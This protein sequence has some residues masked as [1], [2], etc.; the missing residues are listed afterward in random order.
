MMYNKKEESEKRRLAFDPQQQ[1]RCSGALFL[2][3]LLL[4]VF[5]RCSN[6]PMQVL[7][8]L[9][10]LSVQQFVYPINSDVQV[11]SVFS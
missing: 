9:F 3:V 10:F 5:L 4:L 11:V 1:T 7:L 6:V 8:N 2:R